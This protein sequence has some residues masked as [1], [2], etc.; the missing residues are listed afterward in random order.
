MEKYKSNYE[1][2]IEDER[3]KRFCLGIVVAAVIVPPLFAF[4]MTILTH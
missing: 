3:S 2:M 4:A 1:R